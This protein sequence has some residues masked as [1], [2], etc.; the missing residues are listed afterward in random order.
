MGAGVAH[1]DTAGFRIGP[2]T[3]YADC[4][5]MTDWANRA[6]P[7]DEMIY[8][9]GPVLGDHAAARSAR[10]MAERGLVELFQRRSG[11]A[12]CFDYCARRLRP[13]ASLLEDGENPSSAT[14]LP[15][16][17]TLPLDEARVYQ[18]VAQAA[19]AGEACP[20]LA[21]L[22]TRCHLESRFRAKYLLGRLCELGLLTKHDR[23]ADARRDAPMVFTVAL[24]AKTTRGETG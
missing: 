10:S 3:T 13:T 6:Q 5:A 15:D 9:T 21:R 1:A 14:S 4:A 16:P 11:R 19:H 12:N 2:L 22:A 24:L 8:A 17:L 20:S 23:S 18:C 7:G